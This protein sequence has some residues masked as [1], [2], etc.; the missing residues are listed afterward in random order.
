VSLP[1]ISQKTA[2]IGMTV[3]SAIVLIYMLSG[4]FWW[5]LSYSGF[6]VALHAFLRDASKHKVLDDADDLEEPLQPLQE[7]SS[8][9][10]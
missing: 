10:S 4:I 3:I 2:T 7:E 8:K 5:T 1:E 6:L 9:S